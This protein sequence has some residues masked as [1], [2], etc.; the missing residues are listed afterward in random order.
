MWLLLPCHYSAQ[1]HH[2]T[3][4][5]YY[6][7]WD[8]MGVPHLQYDVWHLVFMDIDFDTNVHHLSWTVLSTI[9]G[10]CIIFI[11]SPFSQMLCLIPHVCNI[12]TVTSLGT[13]TV[14]CKARYQCA[15]PGSKV[16][17][18]NMGP[19]WGQHD[20]GG[21]HVGPMNFA[22]WGAMRWKNTF[23]DQYSLCHCIIASFDIKDI[24]SL[25]P[26]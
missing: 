11:Y 7:P 17:G 19:I 10:N 9:P 23:V 1:W 2:C 15:V 25:L 26:F 4:Y 14:P 12:K 24:D 22:I 20:P 18:A 5:I 8:P 3:H 6:C 13:N 21:P 16:H